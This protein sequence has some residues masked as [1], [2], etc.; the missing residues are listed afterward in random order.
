MSV[1]ISNDIFKSGIIKPASQNVQN[2][3]IYPFKFLNI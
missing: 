2:V 3:F 1:Q